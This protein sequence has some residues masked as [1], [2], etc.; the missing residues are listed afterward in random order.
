MI[1]KKKHKLNEIQFITFIMTMKAEIDPE[2]IPNA[3]PEVVEFIEEAVNVINN[4][5]SPIV[6]MLDVV[7]T[8]I[9]ERFVIYENAQFNK[10]MSRFIINRILSVETT[11]KFLKSQTKHNENFQDLQH[12]ESFVNFQATL[13][14]IKMFVEK[15]TR[16]RAFET[17]L[18][19]TNIKKEFTELMKE[20]E[21][22]MTDLNFTMII[23]FNEQ[24]RIDNNILTD[25]YQN[26]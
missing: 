19:A 6:P 4:A 1:K 5:L 11:I 13:R 7:I 24:R 23:V 2:T 12:Q 8:L 14:K 9:N 21:A 20:Y 10:R 17:F 3:K 25:T 26:N 15:V 22:C 16:L 18:C